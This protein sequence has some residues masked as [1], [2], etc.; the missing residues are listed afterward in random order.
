[1][2][3]LSQAFERKAAGDP[4]ALWEEMFRAGRSS[5]SGQVITLDAALKCSVAM[6]CILV[7]AACWSDTPLKLFRTEA[8]GAINPATDDPRYDLMAAQPNPWSTSFEY[9]ETLGIHQSL[10]NAYSFINRIGNG[11][12]KEL[13]PLNPTKVKKERNP[14]YSII[15]KVTG[16]SGAV[17]IFPAE[18]IWH[19]PGPSWDGVLGLDTLV[20]AKEALGLSIATEESHAKLHAAG[21]RPSGTY[22]VEGSLNPLQYAALKAWIIKENAGAENAGA[23]MILDRGAK[24]LSTAMSG[25][26]AQHLETRKFQI[27]EVSRFFR[28]MPIMIGYSDKTATFASAEAMFLAHD[29]NTRAPLCRRFELSANVNLLSAKDR[30]AGLGFKFMLNSTMRASHTDRANY[31]KAA[32]GSG[33]APAWMT[34]DEI[35]ALEELNPMGGEAAS[36]PARVITAAPAITPQE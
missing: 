21:V 9:L 19:I 12:I 33:N 26:D 35:R 29:V 30:A 8:S 31:F 20:L 3:V 10:G 2:G 6:G 4:L 18:A 1:M 32:L 17:Q 34:Q 14:D 36:L 5:K 28:V 16:D 25:L 24:W 13:I 11:K 23:P 15:Y 27:E 7:R 22:S